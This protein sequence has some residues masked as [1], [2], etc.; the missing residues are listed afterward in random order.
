MR[1]TQPK[2]PDVYVPLNGE[3]GN[4]FA[5]LG[6]VTQALKS[7]GVSREEIK[8]FRLEATSGDYNNLLQVVLSWIN[9]GGEEEDE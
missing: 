1:G 2:H 6:R 3:D 4:A 9:E 5:I 7:A 8:A